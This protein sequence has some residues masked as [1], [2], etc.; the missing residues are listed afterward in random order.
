MAKKTTKKPMPFILEVAWSTYMKVRKYYQS[1]AGDFVP[2]VAAR[3]GDETLY[4]YIED[5]VN[6]GKMRVPWKIWLKVRQRGRG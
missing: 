1:D 4:L 6:G 5:R 3:P 2:E